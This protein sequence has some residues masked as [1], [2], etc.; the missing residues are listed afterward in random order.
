MNLFETVRTN[1][2]A[3]DVVLMAGFQPNRSKMI[4]CPFHNDKHPSMK[5]DRRYFCFGCG[6]K[7]DAVDFVANYYGLSLKEAAE[8]IISDFGLTYNN[9]GYAEGVRKPIAA[10]RSE[11]QIWA[12]KKQELFAHLSR[13]H[14]QLRKMKIEY[15]PKERE[16]SEWSP[17]FVMVTKELTYVEYLYDYCM[18]EAKISQD[19]VSLLVLLMWLIFCHWIGVETEDSYRL[20]VMLPRQ[21]C[22]FWRMK[23]R[24]ERILSRCGRK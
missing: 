19:S 5:V 10:K 20:C 8:K 3:V 16:D 7:G 23:L 12:E 18:F 21:R 9:T 13:L 15:A 17:L 14:E 11:Y 2:K 6:V 24:H 1:V 22:I 4:C